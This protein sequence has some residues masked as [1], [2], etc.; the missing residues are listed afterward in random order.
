MARPIEN[1]KGR[2]FG[3]LEVLQFLAVIKGHAVWICRCKCGKKKSATAPHLKNGSTVSCGCYHSEMTRK[4]L[5]EHPLPSAH[6]WKHGESRS[7]EY[8]VWDSMIRR[9]LDPENPTF[10]YYGG[11]KITVCLRWRKFENFLTDMG[12]KP[13]GMHGRRS[14]YSIE[15]K[16][17]DGDYEPENCKWATKLE[18]SKNRRP[19]K[20]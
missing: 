1:L 7:V 19:K 6:K 18:Q 11:R 12:R 14:L 9:C 5:H 8:K 16:N 3:R 20:I 10:K 2:R 17:N 4:R 13:P 15:R